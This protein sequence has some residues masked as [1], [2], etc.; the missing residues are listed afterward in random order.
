MDRN[1]LVEVYDTALLATPFCY[2]DLEE[3]IKVSGIGLLSPEMMISTI[4]LAV[5]QEATSAELSVE[6]LEMLE[7]V[8]GDMPD[9][10]IIEKLKDASFIGELVGLEAIIHSFIEGLEDPSAI[11]VTGLIGFIARV[12]TTDHKAG[13]CGPRPHLERLL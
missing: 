4:N 6:E 12:I 13:L 5:M 11:E 3:T 9:E 7:S 1:T 2:D 8:M 10:A